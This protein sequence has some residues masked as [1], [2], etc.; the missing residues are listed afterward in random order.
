MRRRLS[1]IMYPITMIDL[2]FIAAGNVSV[3]ERFLLED[4]MI[5]ISNIDVFSS[6]PRWEDDIEN[7]QLARPFTSIYCCEEP[8][9]LLENCSYPERAHRESVTSVLPALESLL[10]ERLNLSGPVQE[11]IGQ[12]VA[13]RQFAQ[14]QWGTVTEWSILDRTRLLLFIILL[15]LD[16]D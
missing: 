7:G 8:L 11:A 10:V 1:Q 5:E 14:L 9:L 13:A 15:F 3:W 6:L 2:L 12:F 4:C 16:P